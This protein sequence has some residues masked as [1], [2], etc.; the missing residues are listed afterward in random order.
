MKTD[1][2]VFVI[3]W[4]CLLSLGWYTYSLNLEKKVRAD[5]VREFAKSDSETTAKVCFAWYFQQTPTQS[6][7][8]R[9]LTCK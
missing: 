6:D 9:K 8:R 3:G 2:V 7:K 1:F 4:T 5:V